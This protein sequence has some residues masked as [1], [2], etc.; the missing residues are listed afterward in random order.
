MDS[1]EKYKKNRATLEAAGFRENHDTM[2]W[3]S[4]DQRKAFSHEAMSDNDSRWLTQRLV[5]ELPSAEFWFYF[6]FISDDP[7]PGCKQILTKMQLAHL[8]P[9]A[10]GIRRAARTSN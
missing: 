8:T 6:S 3:L 2:V 7:M 9:R 4:R 5:E 1:D 10:H